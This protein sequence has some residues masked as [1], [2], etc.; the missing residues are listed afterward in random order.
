MAILPLVEPLTGAPYNPSFEKLVRLE[1]ERARQKHG[2]ILSLHEGY[3][4]ILE[5]VDEFWDE[6][7]KK[8]LSRDQE[9]VLS[10]LVQVAAMCQAVAEDILFED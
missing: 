9:K 7:K 4:I 1:L 3:S 8:Q 5:E 10:E 6:V 2:P